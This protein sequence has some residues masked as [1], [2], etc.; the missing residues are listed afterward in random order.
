MAPMT[1]QLSTDA[2]C[3]EGDEVGPSSDDPGSCCPDGRLRVECACSQ[4]VRARAGDA[5]DELVHELER[6]AGQASRELGVAGEL[7]ARLVDDAE[8]ARVHGAY[9]GAEG[10]TDVI[11]FDLTGGRSA[12]GEA[13][14]ADLLIC[15]DEASRRSEQSGV[16]IAHELVLYLLHGL[17]HCLGE[18]DRDE[19]S[20]ARMHARE[21]AVL[22]AI[23]LGR[24]FGAGEGDRL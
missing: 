11:T 24:V 8:M 12:R 13:I 15:M 16:P 4:A 2:A 17:L 18:N 21:D 22:E 14:D 7:R 1:M 19:A 20:F 3:G 10:T 6:L 23:G 5:V 9:C